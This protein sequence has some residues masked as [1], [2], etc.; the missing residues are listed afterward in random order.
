MSPHPWMWASR[1]TARKGYF[2][3]GKGS[4]AMLQCTAGEHLTLMYEVEQFSFLLCCKSPWCLQACMWH[5]H[6]TPL[7]AGS[8]TK[9]FVCNAAGASTHPCVRFAEISAL[10][11]VTLLYGWIQCSLISLCSAPSW[12]TVGQRPHAGFKTVQ[13]SLLTSHS[14]S[15]SLE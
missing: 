13:K 9:K 4:A 2:S 15:V 10:Q 12:V 11:G 3:S 1:K 14:K 7:P 5:A 8:S 6:C